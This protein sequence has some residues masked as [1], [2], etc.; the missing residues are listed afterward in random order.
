MQKEFRVCFDAAQAKQQLE[1]W[2]HYVRPIREIV[3]Q[4]VP[5]YIVEYFEGTGSTEVGRTD[6]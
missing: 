3:V 5:L 1:E 4:G 2:G 6:G